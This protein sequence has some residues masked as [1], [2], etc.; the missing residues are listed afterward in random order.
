MRTDLFLCRVIHDQG[1]TGF[2]GRDG[3]VGKQRGGGEPAE[4]TWRPTG[5]IAGGSR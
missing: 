1:P 4:G 5:R 2:G 3:D